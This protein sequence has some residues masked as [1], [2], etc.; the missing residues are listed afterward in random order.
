[1]YQYPQDA[2]VPTQGNGDDFYSDFDEDEIKTDSQKQG[3][4]TNA[5]N[6]EIPRELSHMSEA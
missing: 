6:N 3:S 4:T 1:M 5:Q 2:K